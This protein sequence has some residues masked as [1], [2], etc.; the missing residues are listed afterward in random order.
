MRVAYVCADPGV[1]VF[2]TKG[3]SIHVQEVLRV[4]IDRGATVDLFALRAG[5]ERPQGLASV[6][7]HMMP[8][9]N[10]GTGPVRERELLAVNVILQKM[11][12][13]SGPFDLVYERHSLWAYGAMEYAKHRSV[14]NILEINAPLIEEQ[15][16]HRRLHSVPSAR[17]AEHRA[18]HAADH[19]IAVSAP[20]AEYV[21]SFNVSRSSISVVPNGV[22][23]ERF[24]PRMGQARRCDASFTV[25]F[26]GTL[27]PWHGV[28]DLVEAYRR[29]RSK[30]SYQDLQLRIVGDGPQLPALQEQIARL[31]EDMR[32]GVEFVGTIA[33]DNV[34][35][36][37]ARFD[38][39]VAPYTPSQECY[40]SPI[41]L[42]E[43]MAAGL[44]IVAA[45]S[46]QLSEI[47]RD[48]EN[49][50]LYPP[51]DIDALAVALCELHD[52]EAQ[53]DRL[54][55]AARRDV[56]QRHTWHQ[57]VDYI[58]DLAGTGPCSG[59]ADRPGSN[60]SPAWDRVHV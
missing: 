15:L 56:E 27:R 19:I 49:G 45:C 6:R 31:P 29:V 47:I 14:A 18:F 26:L 43:Y 33:Y 5:G 52:D 17:W 53:S 48:G 12:A 41:K 4:L 40:F 60:A 39:A 9:P 11:L 38:V 25:G 50:R 58:L 44:P 23:V 10:I 51:G 22:R 37:L 7:L 30:E 1:P 42:F 46:G 24:A 21:A 28:A 13:D 35:A 3:C 34:P 36:E 8:K 57:R 55:Q 59:D 54:A 2:G 32:M 20:V 16:L